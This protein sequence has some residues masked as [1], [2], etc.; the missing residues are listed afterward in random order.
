MATNEFLCG[1][2]PGAVAPH[3]TPSGMV[4]GAGSS[5]PPASG[6]GVPKWQPSFPPPLFT[7]FPVA[8]P[9]AQPSMGHDSTSSDTPEQSQIGSN[10]PVH[11]KSIDP[12]GKTVCEKEDSSDELVLQEPNQDSSFD[13]SI[14]SNRVHGILQT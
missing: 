6:M 8:F 3:L 7:P 5:M 12:E 10:L 13:P 1:M 4:R 2:F 11:R 9:A 14:E